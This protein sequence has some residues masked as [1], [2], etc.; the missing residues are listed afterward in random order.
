MAYSFSRLRLN[1]V[2]FAIKFWLLLCQM[3]YINSN[4][5]IRYN[6]Y[7]VMFFKQRSCDKMID[8]SYSKFNQKLKIYCI[9]FWLLT[10]PYI[11]D[12]LCICVLYMN[13]RETRHKFDKG[14]WSH[15]YQKLTSTIIYF[16]YNVCQDKLFLKSWYQDNYIL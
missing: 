14:G 1:C 3:Y 9:S 7:T 4:S 15:N 12:K 16:L 11:S 8:L 2:N 6:I 5:V 10:K 13:T